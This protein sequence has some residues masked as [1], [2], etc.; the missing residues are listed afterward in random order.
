MIVLR[1]PEV[2][3]AARAAAAMKKP[4]INAGDGVGEHPTQALLD[5][6]T[7]SSSL[8]SVAST[9]LAGLHLVLLGDLKHGRTVHSLILLVSR[10]SRPPRI[11]LVSPAQL[12]MPSHITE[13]CIK[14]G[15]HIEESTML[16]DA[17][18]SADVIYVT[19]VQRERFERVEDYE[20]VKGSYVISAA[21]MAAAKSSAVVLHPLPRVDEI[22]TDFDG[23]PRARYFEQAR[24][25]TARLVQVTCE[26]GG[27]VDTFVK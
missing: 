7:I 15:V 21:S 17:L 27:R 24:V 9:D 10:L 5:L 25:P 16:G 3:T 4:L 20:A 22:A 18:R 12:R 23:D 8:R 13:E 1:H 6:Y 11:T 14:R 2:G 19:R 26:G